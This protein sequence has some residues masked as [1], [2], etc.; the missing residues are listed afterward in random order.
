MSRIINLIELLNEKPMTKQDITFEYAFDER[1]TN[2]YTDAG[3]YLDLIDKHPDENR[4]IVFSL[5]SCGQ[6]IMSLGYRERQLA[7]VAQILKHKV[8]NEVLKMHLQFAE[9]PDAQTVVQVMRQSKLYRVEADSTYVRRSS[10]IVGWINGI[11]S[12]VEE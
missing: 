10:T 8:F 11:L 7:I 2:Y 4:N 12:I 1:Q 6:Y 3:R 5:S 9:M